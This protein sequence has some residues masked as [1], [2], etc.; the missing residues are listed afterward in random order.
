[1]NMD[2]SII[3]SGQ[4][5]NV[6]GAMSAGNDLAAQTMGMRRQQ[7]VNALYKAQGPGIINGDPGALNALAQ[8]DPTAALGIKQTQ[9]GMSFD[10]EKMAML[11]EQAKNAAADRAKSLSAEQRAA[12]TAQIESGLKGAAFF[13][14]SGNRAGFDNFI[15]Q[16]GLDPA[17]Y[18]FDNFPAIAA[19]YD[20][21][22]EAYKTFAPAAP[23][24]PIKG[25][26][27]GY[28]WNDPTD[29]RK[30]MSP[31]P[32]FNNGPDWLAAT[33]EQAA[34]YGSAAGQINT[35]TGE[36]KPINPPKGMSITSDGKGGFTFTDGPGAGKDPQAG[37]M[38]PASPEAMLS[39]INGILDDPALSYSTG[40]LSVLQ[41]VPGTPMKRVQ[42]R[43]NQLNGQAFLQAFAS[44]KGGGQITETEGAK[45]TAAIGRLDS[46]Q[47]P[48]DYKSALTELKDILVAAQTR[49]IGWAY[50]QPD[51]TLKQGNTPAVGAIE[52]GYRFKGGNS[53]DPNAWEKVN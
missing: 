9:Q 51:P 11:R 28:A 42:G 52:D 48:E 35:K 20:G 13:Y 8:Y 7:E 34:Q 29:P 21:V 17:Q 10:A 44:L 43:V 50:N 24:D 2:P 49:P 25:A 23:P 26:P 6:L 47:S 38:Q 12:E 39:T 16:Q 33:P 45:A 15:K 18:S 46:S 31:I 5:V 40:A 3:L 4:P 30:G 53:A 1:M 22:L 32:G 37:G 36:F 27:D 14:Q 41:N 19:Q